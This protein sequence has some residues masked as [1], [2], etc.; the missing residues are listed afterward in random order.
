MKHLITKIGLNVTIIGS[1]ECVSG[2]YLLGQL[3]NGEYASYYL[4]GKHL[5]EGEHELDIVNFEV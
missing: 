5:S 1:R 3:S 2:T 4:N